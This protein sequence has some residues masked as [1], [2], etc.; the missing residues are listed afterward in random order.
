MGVERT[1]SSEEQFANAVGEL[2]ADGE[3]A[4]A[5]DDDRF[6]PKDPAA[7]PD[8]DHLHASLMSPSREGRASKPFGHGEPS[9]AG[10]VAAATEFGTDGRTPFRDG[11]RMAMRRAGSGLLSTLVPV[12]AVGILLIA[13]VTLM[14]STLTGAAA[15]SRNE[16]TPATGLRGATVRASGEE[17]LRIVEGAAASVVGKEV[18]GP[19]HLNASLLEPM[20]FDDLEKRNI[21]EALDTWRGTTLSPAPVEAPAKGAT[22]DPESSSFAALEDGEK[23]EENLEEDVTGS[24]GNR[25]SITTA[26]I[27]VRSTDD[28]SNSS[29]SSSS[30]S[31]RSSSSTPPDESATY[32][33]AV[34]ASAAAAIVVPGEASASAAAASAPASP[35]LDAAGESE[36]EAEVEVDA[37]SPATAPLPQVVAPSAIEGQV[38]VEKSASVAALETSDDT[39]DGSEAWNIELPEEQSLVGDR[40]ASPDATLAPAPE[41]APLYA[42]SEVRSG[43]AAQSQTPDAAVEAWGGSAPRGDGLQPLATAEE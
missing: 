5:I 42:A 3:V 18:G 35:V 33:E 27:S 2:V 12:V 25:S 34:A 8:T 31:S 28:S 11:H 14:A 24:S 21:S 29:S 40:A 4:C 30:S 19:G 10:G 22:I 43:E 16:E 13:V 7:E 39:G 6:F 23:Q 9:S 20:S 38:Q 17:G 1:L 37:S 36:A 32:E 15:E 26:S 41:E